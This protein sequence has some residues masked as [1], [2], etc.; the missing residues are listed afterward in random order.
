MKALVPLEEPV[1]CDD[2]FLFGAECLPLFSRARVC[3][4][5]DKSLTSTDFRDS[6]RWNRIVAA[7]GETSMDVI[8]VRYRLLFPPETFGFILKT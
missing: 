7:I 2:W 8:S 3:I 5:A 1:V 6:S 4:A